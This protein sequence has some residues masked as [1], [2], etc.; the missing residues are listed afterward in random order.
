MLSFYKKPAYFFS[1]IRKNNRIRFIRNKY[2]GSK[3]YHLFRSKDLNDKNTAFNL[4]QYFNNRGSLSFNEK[5]NSLD[6]KKII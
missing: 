1:Y 5:Q 6:T 3:R 4:K 2:S